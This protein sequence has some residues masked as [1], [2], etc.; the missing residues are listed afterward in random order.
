MATIKE[1]ARLAGVSATTV[2][3]VIHGNKGKVSAEKF[4]KVEK[5]LNDL[6]F[7]PNLAAASA[8]SHPA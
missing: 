6:H 8:A 4:A 1:I 3:N 2:S 5:I 7:A